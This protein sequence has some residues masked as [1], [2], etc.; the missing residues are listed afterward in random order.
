VTVFWLVAITNSFNLI[1]GLDG[2]ASGVAL[3]ACSATFTAAVLHRDSSIA[4]VSLSFGAALLAFLVYNFNPAS[5]FM[6]D[7]GALTLGFVLGVLSL[8]VA[9]EA[10]NSAMAAYTF[11]LFLLAVPLL[12]TSLVT[13]TRVATGRAIFARGLDHSHHRLIALGLRYRS[14][15]L[16]CWAVEALTSMYALATTVMP[17]IY[18]IA[19]LPMIMTA[20]APYALFLVDLTFEIR[21]PGITYHRVGRLAKVIL[22]ISYRMRIVDIALDA[23]MA[24]AAYFA[25]AI[26]NVAVSDGLVSKVLNGL[27][28]VLVASCP[29]FFVTGVYRGLWRYA[30]FV[31]AVRFGKGAALAGSLVLVGSIARLIPITPSGAAL[32]SILL[33]D[34]LLASRF[35]FRLMRKVLVAVTSPVNRVLIVGAG[36]TGDA[37]VRDITTRTE[38]SARIIGFVDDDMFKH[39]KL[40]EGLPVLGTIENLAKIYSAHKFDEIVIAANRIDEFRL[41]IVRAF[42]AEHQLRLFQYSVKFSEV[43]WPQNEHSQNVDEASADPKSLV[44]R[45]AAST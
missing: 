20:L 36:R 16:L 33:L 18:L 41:N 13:L 7:G 24:A 26:M 40:I 23:T 6:G 42:T 2:L 32:F 31:D 15:V 21:A 8:Q 4:L 10:K 38:H 34:L 19:T 39:G 9:A 3:I 25:V 35:S 43:E 44:V 27:P 37:A 45:E 17:H 28:W 12:D 11:P 29:A 5:I 1:D 14:A 30:G 22:S